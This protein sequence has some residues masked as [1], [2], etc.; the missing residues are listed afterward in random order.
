M[1]VRFLSGGLPVAAKSPKSLRRQLLPPGNTM[2]GN[3]HWPSFIW[4]VVAALVL[5]G[6][7]AALVGWFGSEGG[8]D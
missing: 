4:G 3:I 8:F 2:G 1:Q 6:L 5:G 7:G